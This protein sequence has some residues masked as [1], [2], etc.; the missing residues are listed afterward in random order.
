MIDSN[1]DP[2]ETLAEAAEKFKKFLSA[3]H[4]PQTISWL[5]RDNVLVDM[6]VSSGF[7]SEEPRRLSRRSCDIPRAFSATLA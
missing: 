5:M 2:P 3:Q 7:V 4:W 6:Q 1:S